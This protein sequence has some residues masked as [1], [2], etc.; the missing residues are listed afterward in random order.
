MAAFERLQ[1]AGCIVRGARLPTPIKDADPC[2]G[3]GAHGR[4][5]RLGLVAL[6]LGVELGP[7]GMPDRCRGPFH[8]RLAQE[9]RPLEAP[10]APGLLATA[11]R[12]RCDACIVLECC[13]RGV[14]VPLCAQG[15]EEARGTA[16]TGA[17]PGVTQGEG[18]MVWGA[19]RDGAVNVG[20]GRHG[21][22]QWGDE[23]LHQEPMGGG[24]RR[25]RWSA[26]ARA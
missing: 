16:R 14:A 10:V 4:L 1:R 2:A 8:A 17:W 22:P 3:Q 9:R 23:G 24:G 5:V 20:H 6:R 19:V 12:A 26:R 13:G 21:D 18:G 7:E 15:H 25:H 11:F